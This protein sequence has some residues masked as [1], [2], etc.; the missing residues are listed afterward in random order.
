MK[1]S[2]RAVVLLSL[3]L[4]GCTAGQKSSQPLYLA[5]AMQSPVSGETQITVPADSLAPQPNARNVM[6]YSLRPLP[7]H[8]W[9]DTLDRQFAAPVMS[10][11]VLPGQQVRTVEISGDVNYYGTERYVNGALVGDIVKSFPVPAQRI[12]LTPGKPVVLTLP[13]GIR[14]TV[15]LTTDRDGQ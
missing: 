4:A 10:I 14:F 15:K 6:L 5:T 13:R 2:M 1:H 8:A 9:R 12:Q 11:N 7:G 3:A